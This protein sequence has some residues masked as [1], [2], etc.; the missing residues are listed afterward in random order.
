[1]AVDGG[2]LPQGSEI[3]SCDASSP[4]VEPAVE[5]AFILSQMR[6]LLPP[7]VTNGT[8]ST[9]ATRVDAACL[10][11]DLSTNA[12]ASSFMVAQGIVPLLLRIVR[13]RMQHSDRLLETCLGTLANL[14]TDVTVCDAIAA[15]DA[16]SDLCDVLLSS[17]NSPVLLELLRTLS[18]ALSTLS[19]SPLHAARSAYLHRWLSLLCARDPLAQLLRV[20]AN[21]RRRD[22]LLVGLGLLSALSYVVDILPSLEET[23]D[24]GDSAVAPPEAFAD[25]LPADTA[26]EDDEAV[27]R[28]RGGGARGRTPTVPAAFA[29]TFSSP[30]STTPSP[31]CTTP[32]TAF[33]ETLLS[34]RALPVLA[35]LLVER[36]R[37]GEV[38][39]AVLLP[40]EE[41]LSALA[42]EVDSEDPSTHERSGEQGATKEPASTKV[43]FAGNEL[44]AEQGGTAQSS[45]TEGQSAGLIQLAVE[46][47]GLPVDD[48]EVEGTAPSV[49]ERGDPLGT[50]I[51]LASTEESASA[52][53]SS[54]SLIHTI[55]VAGLPTNH[56]E[57]DGQVPSMNGRQAEEASTTE[58]VSTNQPFAGGIQRA[59]EAAGLPTNH[60]VWH[61]LES[62]LE[63]AGDMPIEA[64]SIAC[65]LIAVIALVHAGTALLA[66]PSPVALLRLLRM[67]EVRLLS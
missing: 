44:V 24:A 49:Q 19:L 30:G 52:M 34:S 10:I 60:G 8:S 2:A 45:L 61:T 26:G 20:L 3:G 6:A 39:H 50:T 29:D 25:A 53:D 51:A 63:H 27:S 37:D 59:I 15:R 23:S 5:P 18:A 57:V 13:D 64:A 58:F 42:N 66:P 36:W 14:A 1:M 41:M 54:A 31:L 48:G 9:D 46:G 43:S 17:F 12:E 11:W 16:W 33:A 62:I 65:S 7:E 28:C 47:A 21:T 35:D 55:E 40:L 32:P 4:P 22:V 67:L 38:C 56:G